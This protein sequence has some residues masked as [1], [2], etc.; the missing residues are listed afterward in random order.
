MFEGDYEPEYPDSLFDEND[1]VMLNPDYFLSYERDDS[2][3]RG[4]IDNLSYREDDGWQYDVWMVD[5][6]LEQG[7]LEHGIERKLTEEELKQ[8]EIEKEANKYNL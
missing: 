4:K 2:E 3:C 1:Y 7:V 5:G 8:L 6:S